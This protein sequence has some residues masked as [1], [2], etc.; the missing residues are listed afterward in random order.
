MTPNYET[1]EIETAGKSECI[2]FVSVII[3]PYPY[4]I[5]AISDSDHITQAQ[6]RRTL[7]REFPQH[8]FTFNGNGGK[9]TLRADAARWPGDGV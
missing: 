2:T 4:P 6:M 7:D 9:Y 1:R 5:V 3:Y 8:T